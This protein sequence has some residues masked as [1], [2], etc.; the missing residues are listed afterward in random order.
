[1]AELLASKHSLR[2]FRGL[3]SRDARPVA[4][5]TAPQEGLQVM[6]VSNTLLYRYLAM[7]QVVEGDRA[8][9]IGSAH[10]HCTALLGSSAVGVDLAPEMVAEARQLHPE[11]HFVCADIFCDDLSWLDSEATVLFV[12]IN[13][14]RNYKPVMKALAIGIS[15]MPAL[16]LIVAKSIEVR[17]FLLLA[18]ESVHTVARDLLSSK[19][20]DA[21]AAEELAIEIRRHGGE[22][23]VSLIFTLHCGLRLRYIV[24]NQ[25]HQGMLA[26]LKKQAL[27][28]QLVD[29]E[30]GPPEMRLR[31]RALP[32][33]APPPPPAL[34]DLQHQLAAK[35]RQ[36]LPPDNNSWKLGQVFG[37]IKPGFFKR[38][39]AAAAEPELH[40]QASDPSLHPTGSPVCEPW[41]SA[42][43]RGVAMRHFHA[44][45]IASMPEVA[46]S[47]EMAGEVPTS[48]ELCNLQLRRCTALE[49]AELPTSDGAGDLCPEALLGSG[50]KIVLQVV[51]GNWRAAEGD[52]PE[53]Q[54]L[55]VR[56]AWLLLGPQV[57][58]ELPNDV[59]GSDSAGLGSSSEKLGFA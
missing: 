34:R 56:R 9:E 2:L 16:R 55:F 21:E 14:N 3:S 31:V 53:V 47:G 25:G 59:E 17:S 20:D 28:L 15:H 22:V 45:L 13:G 8:V 5:Q 29:V 12:D 36:Q 49:P 23:P 19:D 41:S 7:T 37:R 39:L 58:E 10:G 18:K 43:Q 44:F 27:L 11:C 26:F 50:Q 48:E 33:E 51:D 42:W 24:G 1:M 32:G 35:V 57:V 46:V 30:N 52:V 40:R 54:D 4:R 6:V 38:Y